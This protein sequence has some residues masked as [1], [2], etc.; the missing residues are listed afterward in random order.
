MFKF[1]NEG[2]LINCRHKIIQKGLISSVKYNN[3]Q[4]PYA[5]PSLQTQL[6]TLALT[7]PSSID[8]RE[9]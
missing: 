5:Y 8:F 2:D 6:N 7:L 9:C 4:R 3:V 1:L